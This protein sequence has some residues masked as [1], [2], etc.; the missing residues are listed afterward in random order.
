VPPASFFLPSTGRRATLPL[1]VLVRVVQVT[2]QQP[3][4]TNSPIRQYAQ[5]SKDKQDDHWHIDRR[6]PHQSGHI[7]GFSFDSNHLF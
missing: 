7:E 5:E 4:R 6:I 3:T 2:E 1:A